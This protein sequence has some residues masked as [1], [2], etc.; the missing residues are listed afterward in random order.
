[1]ASPDLAAQRKRGIVGVNDVPF[2]EILEFQRRAFPDRREDWVEP[3]WRWMFLES[4]ARLDTA[5][6]VWM[7]L[8]K[9]GLVAQQAGIPVQAQIGHERLLTGWFVETMVL[10]VARGRAVGPMLVAKAK[11][12]LPF[13]LSLGQTP[14]MREMQFRLGWVEVAPLPTYV[15]VLNGASVVRGKVPGWA[16]WP[17]GLALSVQQRLR[18]RRLPDTA[19]LSVREITSCGAEHDDLWRRV[20]AA[21]RCAVVRDSSYL[22]WKYR[23]QPGPRYVCLEVSD[24]RDLVALAVLKILEPEPGYAYRRALIVEL[25]APPDSRAITSF[26]LDAACRHA[27][28]EGADLVVFDLLCPALEAHVRDFGFD[29]RPS[30]RVFL[31]STEGLPDA[32]RQLAVDPANWL[33][34]RGDSDIDRPW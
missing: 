29:R 23:D 5:P 32:T 13:N 31:I 4:A 7:Y 9:D 17:A 3:R 1:M 20:G 19:G 10:E 2:E 33:L 30:T 27:R 15:Y 34:T 8:G 16:A 21:F 22:N 12:L 6:Q 18:R 14:T 24:G 26:A 11:E 25:I 28:A